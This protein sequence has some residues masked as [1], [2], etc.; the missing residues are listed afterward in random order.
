MT[1]TRILSD[2]PLIVISGHQCANNPDESAGCEPLAFQVP[3]AS[4]WGDRFLLAPFSGR[5]TEQK[6]RLISTQPTTVMYTCGNITQVATGVTNLVFETDKYCSLASTSPVLVV[7][8]SV[9]ATVDNLGDPAIAMVSPIDQYISETTFVSFP[10]DT[11]PSSYISVTVLAEHFSETSIV[12]DGGQLDCSWQTIY[13]SNNEITG[14]GCSLPVSV[15]TSATVSHNSGGLISVTVYGFS[16]SP[17]L[18]YAYLTG[19]AFTSNG[20]CMNQAYSKNT[21]K[22]N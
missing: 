22:Q 6:F 14:Y 12:L 21:C 4:T 3:P 17:D 5:A 8:L 10:N 20:E 1:G 16:V 15:S 11:F 7:Q 13:S 2:K 18:G 19:Q 9:G